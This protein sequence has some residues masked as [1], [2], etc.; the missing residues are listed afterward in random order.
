VDGVSG[1]YGEKS[2]CSSE[3]NQTLDVK[4]KGIGNRRILAFSIVDQS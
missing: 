1:K 4:A 2:L 3:A